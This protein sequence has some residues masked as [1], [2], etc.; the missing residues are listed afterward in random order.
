MKPKTDYYAGKNTPSGMM[1]YTVKLRLYSDDVDLM[2]Q[3]SITTYVSCENIVNGKRKKNT[4]NWHWC[5][6]DEFRKKTASVIYTAHSS[7]FHK[8]ADQT[9][10]LT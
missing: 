1:K 2:N 9:L 7:Q 3:K 4:F 6:S 10:I 8:P 5:E